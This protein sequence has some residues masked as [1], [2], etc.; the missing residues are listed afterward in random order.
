MIYQVHLRRT[1]IQT[2]EVTVN[3]EP[4]DDTDEKDF[5]YWAI[6]QAYDEANWTQVRLLSLDTKVEQL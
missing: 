4:Q 2:A 5:Q 6:E 3:I 1:I